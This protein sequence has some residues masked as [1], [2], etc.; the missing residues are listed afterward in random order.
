MLSDDQL[1]NQ[2][3]DNENSIIVT[4][5]SG[6]ED[7]CSYVMVLDMLVIAPVI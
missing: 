2:Y 6:I 5:Y 7:D 3:R 4:A 1:L